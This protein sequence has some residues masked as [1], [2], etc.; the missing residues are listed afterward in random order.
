MSENSDTLTVD[1]VIPVAGDRIDA[2]GPA[3]LEP[4]TPGASE[5]YTPQAVSMVPD[6]DHQEQAE[7]EEGITGPVGWVLKV[8]PR[9]N[10]ILPSID[11]RTFVGSVWRCGECGQYYLVYEKRGENAGQ[12]ALRRIA[13]DKATDRLAKAAAKA[14]NDE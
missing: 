14:E 10:C 9:H 13:D 11:T 8:T 5:H 7:G 6:R 3:V 2:T 12:K 1:G 4:D